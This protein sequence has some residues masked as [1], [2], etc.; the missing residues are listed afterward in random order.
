[1]ASAFPGSPRVLKGAL[2]TLDA[3]T[4]RPS[5]IVLQYNP[6]TLTRTLQPQIAGDNAARGDVMRLK[7]APVETIKLDAEIDA[8]DQ[9]ERAAETAVRLGIHPQLAS[10]EMLI[11]P[12][13]GTV[14]ANT[15][16]LASGTIEI[17]PVPAPMTLFVYGAKRVLPVRVSDFSVVEE[18]YDAS[19]NPIRAKVSLGLRVLSYNDLPPSHAGHGLFLAHQVAK[20]AMA[21]LARTADLS[22]VTGGSFT[23]GA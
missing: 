22:A 19:L 4:S 10:L 11:Y 6:D 9:L 3:T 23:I 5:V 17:I 1:M 7:G 20:E 15:S 13:S 8:T 21:A 12:S 14:I 16:L 2:I 18:A